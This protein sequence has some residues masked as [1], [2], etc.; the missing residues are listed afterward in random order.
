MFI[1][2]CILFGCLFG[3][4][5]SYDKKRENKYLKEQ[6][7]KEKYH[8]EKRNEARKAPCVY[9]VEFKC[10]ACNFIWKFKYPKGVRVGYSNF[11]EPSSKH[12]WTGDSHE[13]YN[14]HCPICDNFDDIDII[15]R[16]HLFS[17]QIKKR[18]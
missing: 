4:T 15:T 13:L 9:E 11:G 18:R 17:G 12:G 10:S 14:Y 3:L 5:V 1:I 8:L 2:A 6:Q 16:K 7:D